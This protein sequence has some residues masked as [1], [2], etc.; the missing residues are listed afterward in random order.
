MHR[1]GIRSC[2]PSLPRLICQQ[3]SSS[4]PSPSRYPP[5][6]THPP[7]PPFPTT[8]PAHTP[9]A[10]LPTP[11]PRSPPLRGAGSQ[12][13]TL[14]CPRSRCSRPMRCDMKARQRHKSVAVSTTEP[15]GEG[16]IREEAM[17]AIR[18][19][20]IGLTSDWH[21]EDTPSRTE[22]TRWRSGRPQSRHHR[23]ST[24]SAGI[25]SITLSK[26]SLTLVA[27]LPC[28]LPPA[29]PDTTK[30]RRSLFKSCWQEGTG[31]GVQD[32]GRDKLFHF[33]NDFFGSI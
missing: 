32:Q 24:Y 7:S 33:S 17:S 6:L 15:V 20:N 23:P 30:R 1:R 18:S 22:A 28:S 31:L 14:S 25:G 26:S 13:P 4:Y 21:G 27:S 3:S 9:P 19:S 8:P 29:L 11:L 12:P 16:K 10:P 2:T 5:L